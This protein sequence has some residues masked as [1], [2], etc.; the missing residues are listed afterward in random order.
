MDRLKLIIAVS[1]IA[2]LL[3]CAFVA[4]A[5][6]Q[7][8]VKTSGSN[9]VDYEQVMIDI[10]NQHG[11]EV[12]FGFDACGTRSYTVFIDGY[13]I[14][15]VNFDQWYGRNRGGVSIGQSGQIPNKDYL[16]QSFNIDL[17]SDLLYLLS[18]GQISR[19]EVESFLSDDYELLPWHEVE[20]DWPY[21][22]VHPKE[23]EREKVK[24]ERLYA[25]QYKLY[26]DDGYTFERLYIEIFYLGGLR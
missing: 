16:Y 25:M 11:Y 10:F 20:S 9:N 26:S 2:L 12:Q 14:I 21:E 1:V 7:G 8:N 3:I 18:G 6:L 5:V 19:R 4:L 15:L 17:W 23:D 22:L 24:V 13:S